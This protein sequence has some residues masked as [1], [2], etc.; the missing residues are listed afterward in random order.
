MGQN[1]NTSRRRLLKAALGTGAAATAAHL[2]P[3]TWT[4]PVVEA[5]ILPAHAQATAA[6]F[7]GAGLS[8]FGGGVEG[9]L[10]PQRA[11]QN[12]QLAARLLESVVP[13]AHA[14]PVE[15]TATVCAIPLGGGVIDIALQRS[16]NNARRQGQLCVDGTP[17]VLNVIA[18]SSNCSE[19]P[20]YLNARIVGYSGAGFTLRFAP[21]FV[22]VTGAWIECFVPAGPCPGFAAL[23]GSCTPQ[24]TD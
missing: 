9:A 22:D 21:D 17:G 3:A 1:P 14:Q 19:P 11:P 2:L 20:R 15:P 18:A 13:A 7:G 5:A 16:Q 23:D 6:A 12:T 4:R 8:V 24:I 10:S